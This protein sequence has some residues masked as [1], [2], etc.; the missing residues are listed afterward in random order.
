MWGRHSRSSA[1][2]RKNLCNSEV[3]HHT[4]RPRPWNRQGRFGVYLLNVKLVPQICHNKPQRHIVT[5]SRLANAQSVWDGAGWYLTF[6][7]QHSVF[8]S[9]HIFSGRRDRR[10]L[11]L[12]FKALRK[13]STYHC[14]LVDR[15]IR[16]ATDCKSTARC[17]LDKPA[18]P[19][20]QLTNQSYEETM[21][22][23]SPPPI[24]FT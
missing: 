23:S 20:L 3:H 10:Q 9:G 11:Q 21:A 18:Q 6:L 12:A 16:R 22:M 7:I 19:P 8:R 17:S 2:G 1:Q 5:L 15:V 24:A 13:E 14:Q 4:C